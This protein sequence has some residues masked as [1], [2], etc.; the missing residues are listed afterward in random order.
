MLQEV[1]EPQSTIGT[2]MD[3][4]LKFQGFKPSK[5]R[6]LIIGPT[7]H[8][9]GKPQDIDELP[10]TSPMWVGYAP[11]G[12]AREVLDRLQEGNAKRLTIYATAVSTA[13]EVAE[14]QDALVRDHIRG[15]WFSVWHPLVAVIKIL[16]G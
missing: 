1:T 2:E 8:E 13:E 14:L 10:Y 16:R 12:N 7:R 5:G 9:D 3:G 15:N 4:V 11:A 6:L